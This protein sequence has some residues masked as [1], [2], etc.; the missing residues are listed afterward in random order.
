MAFDLE[1]NFKSTIPLYRSILAAPQVPGSEEPVVGTRRWRQ[2]KLEDSIDEFYPKGQ[3]LITD[4]T[5]ELIKD[6]YYVEAVTYETELGSS[7][8]ADDPEN[9]PDSGV[10]CDGYIR[11]KFYIDEQ[12]LQESVK[13]GY[14]AGTLIWPIRSEYAL[15]DTKINAS[16]MG[17]FDTVFQQ[18]YAKYIPYEKDL[19]AVP[20]IIVSPT[21]VTDKWYQVN[22]TNEEFLM[23][24]RNYMVDPS[25]PKSPY[26]AFINL[27]NQF[28]F[29]SLFKLLSQQP[30]ATL[31]LY[32]GDQDDSIMRDKIIDYEMFWAGTNV[33][34]YNY[35]KE[36]SWTNS[37]GTAMI[38]LPTIQ[39]Y[40]FQSPTDPSISKRN[41]RL[42]EL[43]G[44]YEHPYYGI[45]EPTHQ[46]QF[47]GWQNSLYRKSALS[48]KM[49][50][51]IYFNPKIVAGKMVKL[52]IQDGGTDVVEE[53]ANEFSGNWLVTA[54]KH[55]TDH[56]G[57]G[58]SWIVVARNGVDISKQHKLYGTLMT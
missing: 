12:Q 47:L 41:I 43:T 36:I 28:H 23:L 1:F 19:N 35:M 55:F 26:Y 11:N 57:V 3:L 49:A 16:Y 25:S 17:P 2:V 24:H 53:F 33:N 22:M 50:L 4:N 9:P 56:T 32:N 34:Y 44:P 39:D 14:P 54:S 27:H 21:S 15:Q 5:A 6:D 45:V 13:S 18:I 30:V 37:L 42:S 40:S 48:F 51:H 58:T 7:E 38:D 10:P 46:Q 31:K 8:L 20:P 52:E 29:C